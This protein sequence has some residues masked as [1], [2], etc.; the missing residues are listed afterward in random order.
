MRMLLEFLLDG[1]LKTDQYDL[2]AEITNGIERALD[3]DTGG[4]VSAHRID[5]DLRHGM[6]EN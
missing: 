2:G 4:M 5:G 1:F 6:E 3:H